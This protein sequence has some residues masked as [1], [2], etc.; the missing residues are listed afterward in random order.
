MKKKTYTFVNVFNSDIEIHIKESCYAEA[1]HILSATTKNNNSDY[2]Y[3]EDI[4]KVLA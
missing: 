2:F 1:L 3:K 4:Y